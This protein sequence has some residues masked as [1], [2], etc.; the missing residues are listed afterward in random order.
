MS[1]T[2]ACVRRAGPALAVQCRKDNEAEVN[3]FLREVRGVYPAQHYRANQHGGWQGIYDSKGMV[4]QVWIDSWLVA[5]PEARPYV[6]LPDHM[7]RDLYE[8]PA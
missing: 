8:V 5:L 1:E 4:K 2:A 6:E 3:A 7:F